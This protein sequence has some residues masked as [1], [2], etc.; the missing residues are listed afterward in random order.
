MY[1]R[2]HRGPCGATH[3][4]EVGTIGTC[5]NFLHDNIELVLFPISSCTATQKV[6]LHPKI[7]AECVLPGEHRT[8]HSRRW[9]DSPTVSITSPSASASRRKPCRATSTHRF[10][11]SPGEG[12]GSRSSSSSPAGFWFGAVC[13]YS[14]LWCLGLPIR[15][16]GRLPR[17]RRSPT[18]WAPSSAL[19]SPG[20][21][22][23][24]ILAKRR[25]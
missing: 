25:R 19:S 16:N 23:E 24:Q 11:N 4:V 20:K 17:C 22:G 1:R 9:R 6:V 2:V 14:V 7:L 5:I 3:L 13:V 10:R 15:R 12:G 8:R 21:A 18:G